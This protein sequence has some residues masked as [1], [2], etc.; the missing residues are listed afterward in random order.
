[1]DTL[2]NGSPTIGVNEINGFLHLALFSPHKVWLLGYKDLSHT[3]TLVNCS[4]N[5]CQSDICPP[6]ILRQ[7]RWDF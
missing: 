3:K 7:Q 5:A 2:M 4:N 1:M 6:I